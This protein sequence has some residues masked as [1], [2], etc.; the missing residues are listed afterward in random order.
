[1]S[2]EPPVAEDADDVG[3]RAQRKLSVLDDRRYY[4]SRIGEACRYI[5]FGLLIVFYTIISGDNGFASE[6]RDKSPCLLY[7]VGLFGLLT[8]LADYFHYVAG[9]LAAERALARK[10][11]PFR[12]NTGWTSYGIAKKLF[13]A[14]QWLAAI[15]AAALVLMVLV[16]LFSA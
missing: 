13:A 16:Y 11:K 1:M 7:G 2:D 10:D 6:V 3:A 8:V 5:G 9:Q 15:G 12:Y 4:T 14:K